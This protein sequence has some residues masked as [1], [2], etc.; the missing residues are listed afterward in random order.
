MQKKKRSLRK[1]I[2]RVFSSHYPH[3]WW[4]RALCYIASWPLSVIAH[5]LF[6]TCQVTVIGKENDDPFL[7][8]NLPVLYTSWHSGLLYFVYHFRN[9][10]G[11]I[12][13]SRSMSGELI[14]AILN[15]MGL[16][17]A[18]GSS[19]KK[20]IN[21]GGKEALLKMEEYVN[22]GYSG[23]IVTDAPRGPIY[24]SKVGIIVLS[25]RT[26]T[27]I[28]P[29]IWEAKNCHRF[30]SWDR[31]MLPYP[32]SKIIFYYGEPIFVS[33]EATREE[34]EKIRMQ[35][36]NTLNGMKKEADNYFS[37]GSVDI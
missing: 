36:T 31:T 30:N 18:R 11:V 19:K 17:A 15:R 21:K 2:K 14:V 34:I 3:V 22:Q 25:Q 9:R 10:K 29:I 5:L 24:E 16:K 20:H 35:L 26:G 37:L 27:P 6:A 8:K 1:K 33:K 23:G 4:Y 28:I 32:F 7:R 13:A 12:I